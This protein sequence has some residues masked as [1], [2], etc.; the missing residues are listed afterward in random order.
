MDKGNHPFIE[1]MF[2][3]QTEEIELVGSLIRETS[4]KFTSKGTVL[5]KDGTCWNF[6]SPLGERSET[7]NKLKDMFEKTAAFYDTEIIFH[8]FQRDFSGDGWHN[9]AQGNSHL[10]N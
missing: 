8:R 7:K 3:I 6:R 5:F 10:L 9:P 2:I 4:W 1:E